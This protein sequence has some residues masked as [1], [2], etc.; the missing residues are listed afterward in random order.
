MA[1]GEGV[2]ILAMGMAVGIAV[3]ASLLLA[4]GTRRGAALLAYAL[5][6]LG[7][8]GLFLAAL[9]H[10]ASIAAGV[11]LN[12][13]LDILRPPVLVAAALWSGWLGWLLSASIPLDRRRRPVLALLVAGLADLGATVEHADPGI[14]D[15]HYLFR[16]CRRLVPPGWSRASHRPSNR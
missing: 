14:R 12:V 6:P 1:R 3:A 13:P 5:L 11:G 2:A 15:P 16:G 7:G 9:S 8:A 4:A 10:T